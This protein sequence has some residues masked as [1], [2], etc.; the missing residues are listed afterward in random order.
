MSSSVGSA[1]EVGG[2][3]EEPKNPQNKEIVDLTQEEGILLDK[4][5][6]VVMAG[7][8]GNLILGQ[9]SLSHEVEVEIVDGGC[10][11]AGRFKTASQSGSLAT[12]NEHSVLLMKRSSGAK[13]LRVHARQ[14]TSRILGGPLRKMSKAEGHA[15]MDLPLPSSSSSSEAAAVSFSSAKK[16][17]VELSNGSTVYLAMAYEPAEKRYVTKEMYDDLEYNQL[18]HVL[19]PIASVTGREGGEQE[20]LQGGCS[21]KRTEG[22]TKCVYWVPGRNDYLHHPHVVEMLTQEGWDVYSI[23]L[24]RCGRAKM[25]GQNPLHSHHSDDF[26]EYCEEID[27]VWAL[28]DEVA[29]EGTYRHRIM[30]GHSTGGLIVSMYNRIGKRRQEISGIVLNSP[31]LSLNVPWIAKNVM[32][33]IGQKVILGKGTKPLSDGGGQVNQDLLSI[34][35]QYYYES[36]KRNPFNLDLT[37]G[38]VNAAVDQ[39]KALASMKPHTGTPLLIMTSRSDH[40]LKSA[41][42]L[43][44]VDHVSTF[45]TE[46]EVTYARH[47]VFLSPTPAATNEALGY[48]RTWLQ[49]TLFPHEDGNAGELESFKTPS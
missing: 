26:T 36:G 11:S 5:H 23:D 35:T 32:A 6:V 44:M 24:R 37:K 12:Y 22:H 4:I 13:Q 7:E 15:F 21:Y 30:Y 47:D 17:K 42:L 48:Y 49:N 29:G 8:F 45:R 46:I 28:S 10:A 34:W 39:Q 14:T 3:V 16:V 43:E 27:H 1:S 33:G 41:D 38:W 18:K 2:G 9:G 25:E 40:T 20:P 19:F 31:F